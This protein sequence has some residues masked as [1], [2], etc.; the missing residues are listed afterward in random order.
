MAEWFKWLLQGTDSRRTGSN[1]MDPIQ[2]PTH[3]QA[4]STKV[5]L[6]KQ[7]WRPATWCKKCC[8]DEHVHWVLGVPNCI[9]RL[10]PWHQVLSPCLDQ[11]SDLA[12][13]TC[14]NLILWHI[15]TWLFPDVSNA[16]A[17]NIHA[18]IEFLA[19]VFGMYPFSCTSICRS[20]VTYRASLWHVLECLYLC[21]QTK[22][23]HGGSLTS[24][25]IRP[26]QPKVSC[27]TFTKTQ[28]PHQLENHHP[29]LS[30]I[31]ATPTLVF[32]SLAVPDQSASFPI[33][34]HKDPALGPDPTVAPGC[35]SSA[36]ADLIVESLGI[37]KLPQIIIWLHYA[38]VVVCCSIHSVYIYIY[39]YTYI[40]F[41]RLTT[42]HRVFLTRLRWLYRNWWYYIGESDRLR[43][44]RRGVRRVRTEEE[45]GCA[46]RGL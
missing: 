6:P 42:N 40:F 30:F 39:T 36:W 35:Y 7:S 13:A 26:T 20:Q 12:P 3:A 15:M 9:A 2:W 37:W 18:W 10:V 4:P 23:L 33:A 17:A 32:F 5:R 14:F 45:W 22:K 41:W 43:G 46:R 1:R 31:T 11:K 19:A 25:N 8:V 34:T 27:M 38:I 29:V 44:V 16:E 21:Q 28:W 24:G